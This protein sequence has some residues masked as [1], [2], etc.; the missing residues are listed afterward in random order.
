M[1][2]EDSLRTCVAKYLFSVKFYD[3][4]LDGA[5][6]TKLGLKTAKRAIH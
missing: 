5:L 3:R 1:Q 6:K 2:K 4:L